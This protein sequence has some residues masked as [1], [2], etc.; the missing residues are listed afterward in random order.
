MEKSKRD[1]GKGLFLHRG[2]SELLG[3]REVAMGYFPAAI[4]WALATP[5]PRQI[6]PWPGSRT[7]A[8]VPWPSYSSSLMQLRGQQ[9][10]R[11]F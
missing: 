1:G 11:R 7:A 2:G 3:S 10:A 6:V 8:A 9:I 5:P 4:P